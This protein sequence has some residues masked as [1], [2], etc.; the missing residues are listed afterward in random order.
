MRKRLI[1]VFALVVIGGNVLT[2]EQTGA[3]GLHALL[4]YELL[5]GNED[6]LL[7]SSVDSVGAGLHTDYSAIIKE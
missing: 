7:I 4:T 3:G 6:S 1:I 5:N 2:A